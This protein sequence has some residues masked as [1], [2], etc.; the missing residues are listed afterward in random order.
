MKN[1]K[2]MFKPFV[3]SIN[4]IKVAKKR[5]LFRSVLFEEVTI[6]DYDKDTHHA[7]VKD[8]KG[9]KFYANKKYLFNYER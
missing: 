6:L 5:E 3:I 1:R 2:V 9:H 7:I 4:N 8:E